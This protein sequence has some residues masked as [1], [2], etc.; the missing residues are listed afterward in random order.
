MKFEEMYAAGLIDKETMVPTAI[1]QGFDFLKSGLYR[2]GARYWPQYYA[3][4]YVLDWEG[5]AAARCGFSQPTRKIGANRIECD[6]PPTAK[7]WSNI[8][9]TRIGAGFKNPRLYRKE[10]EAAINRGDIFDPKWVAMIGRYKIIRTMDIQNANNSWMRSVD[11]L[12]SKKSLA[13]GT[14]DSYNASAAALG[15]RRGMPIEVL[16]D[17]AMA[18]D[19][20]LWMTVPGILGAPPVFIDEVDQLKTWQVGQPWIRARA[21]ENAREI[22]NSPEWRKYADEV[23]RSMIA[24]GYPENRT[25]YIELWNEVWNTANPW[26]KMTYY[27]SGLAEGIGGQEGL[28]YR[29]GYGYMTAMFAVTF[30][31]ALKAQGRETQSWISVL[32]GQ[33]ANPATTADALKGFKRYFKDKGLDPAPY[34]K[35]LG[36]S[37]QSY[38]G[39]AFS[40]ETGLI[41]ALDDADRLAK[42]TAAIEADPEGLKKRLTDHILS[43]PASVQGSLPWVVARRAAHQ[44]L[45]EKSGAFFL[46]DYEGGDHNTVPGLLAKDPRFLGWFR[47]WREGPEGER[48][49]KAWADALLAQN[50]EAVVSDYHSIGD[51][52]PGKPWVEAAPGEEN[53]RTRGLA[54]YLRRAPHNP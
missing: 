50:P 13:W 17:M 37:T 25:L 35:R 16:F 12:M 41:K 14:N 32:A 5:E 38:F 19:A 8:E 34:L 31:A 46:G 15:I 27:N 40:V 47:E 43:T 51:F 45:A 49:L 44:A 30:E 26:W 3:G 10:N 53:G 23:V 2:A 29:Y 33:N 6:F 18:G 36:V 42:W 21:K 22:V 24:S 4:T 54:P 20:A 39:D 1:P 28:P 52:Q 48:L 7:D 9:I 11:E